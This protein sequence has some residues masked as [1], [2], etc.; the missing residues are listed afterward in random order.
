MPLP[1]KKINKSDYW[2]TSYNGS[3]KGGFLI[4]KK[5]KSILDINCYT[6]GDNKLPSSIN[7]RCDG[8][9]KK[10]WGYIDNEGI[11]WEVKFN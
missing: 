6:F 9:N 5:F 7:Q 1:I 2:T 11:E 10:Y 4:N 3:T 8:V